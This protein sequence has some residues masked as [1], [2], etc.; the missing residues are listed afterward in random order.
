[1]TTRQLVVGFGLA[2]IAYA[3]AMVV[4]PGPAGRP[5]LGDAVD[6]PGGRVAARTMVARDAILSAGAVGAALSEGS[7]RPWL[8][9]LAL[10]DTADIAATLADADGLPNM[11]A[12]GTVALA[13]TAALSGAAL[14]R[15][16]EQ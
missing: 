7:A 6:T 5:W 8:V 12:I 15:A 10:S 16:V 14:A 2:R 1:M 11:A 4:A 9:A 13:G 3:V